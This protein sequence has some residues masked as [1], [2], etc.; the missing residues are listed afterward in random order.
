MAAELPGDDRW[1]ADPRFELNEIRRPN[2]TVLKKGGV[3]PSEVESYVTRL[4]RLAKDFSSFTREL[5]S[6][7]AHAR[8]EVRDAKAAERRAVDEAMLAAFEAKER[9]ILEAEE[10]AW[11]IEEDARRRATALQET[12]NRL[13]GAENTEELQR[14]LGSY[15]TQVE[16]LEI[17]VER[18]RGR[19]T[20]LEEQLQQPEKPLAAPE[21]GDEAV[22]SAA[23]RRARALMAAARAEAAKLTADAEAEAERSRP[24]AVMGPVGVVAGAEAARLVAEA[25]SRCDEDH[26]GR[27]RRGRPTDLRG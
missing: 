4:E 1:V 23:E 3:D 24:A 2:F 12:S 9:I 5:E 16:D 22:V 25:R 27:P 10:R 17:Q 15:R 26:R 14:E 19:A 13:G 21:D 7:I 18:W 6:R 11:E 20:K 8:A